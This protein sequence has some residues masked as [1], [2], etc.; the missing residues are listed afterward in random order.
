MISR[1]KRAYARLRNSRALAIAI[2]AR[3]DARRACRDAKR[4]GDTRALHVAY[5]KLQDATHAAIRLEMGW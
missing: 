3:E 2:E 5:R 1:I 4:R